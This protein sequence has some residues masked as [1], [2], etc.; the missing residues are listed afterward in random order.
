MANGQPITMRQF[1]GPLIQ[2]RGLPLLLNLVQ[3]ELVKQDAS[4]SHIAVSTDDVR[5]E[6]ELTLDKLFHDRDEKEQE[7]LA[8]AQRKGDKELA[9]K[10]AT[11]IRQEREQFL[12]E[13][14]ENQHYTRVEYDMVIE[15]NAYLRKLAEPL[16]KGKI[17]DEMVQREF[18]IEYGETAQVRVISLSNMQEVQEAQRRLKAGEDFGELAKQMSRDARTASLGGEFPAFS[19]QSPGFPAEFKELAFSLQP[20]QV[21]EALNFRGAY[22]LI[23]LERKFPPKAVKF[24]SVKESLRKS[25]YERLIESLMGQFRQGLGEQAMTK[26][27]ISEPEMAKQFDA[28]K[29]KQIAA[30]RDRQKI[31]EQWK[32]ER[33][34][35]AA[36]QPAATAPAT[37]P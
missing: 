6:E 13:Y 16:A 10:L 32:K 24:D 15:I 22:Y 34:A 1:M 26:L 21:S 19:R 25:M 3:L 17:T 11:Q 36:T 18:G 23:K 31:D 9:A 20:G 33:E 14:L 30:I 4:Q 7:Q 29:A 8:Q 12:G 2:A 5:R 28:L 37:Q 35:Q 27:T